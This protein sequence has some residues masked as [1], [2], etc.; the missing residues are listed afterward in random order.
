MNLRTI[1]EIAAGLS[2]VIISSFASDP[3]KPN[4]VDSNE[5]LEIRKS[6]TDAP[7]HKKYCDVW[8]RTRHFGTTHPT[9]TDIEVVDFKSFEGKEQQITQKAIT[10][11]SG[12]RKPTDN[13]LTT[14]VIESDAPNEF[15]SIYWEGCKW[16][17]KS[18]MK[19]NK[20]LNTDNNDVGASQFGR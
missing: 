5:D 4:L 11:I 12:K 18:E 3:L 8:V 6:Y 14:T 17:S 15:T 19:P 9:E 13:W 16:P 2:F 10:A 1:C 20:S 7:I